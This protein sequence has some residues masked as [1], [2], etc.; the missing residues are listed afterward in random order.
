MSLLQTLIRGKTP[1]MPKGI[2][3]GPP[4]CGKTTFGA[5]APG[6]ILIDCENGANATAANRTPYLETWPQMQSWLRA[7]LDEKHE[8][9][10][11]VIDTIDWL[12]RRMEE[13]VSGAKADAKETLNRSHGGYGNGKQVLKNEIYLNLL[14][15]L[16]KLV[17]QGIGVILLAHASRQDVIDADGVAV[18]KTVPALPRDFLETFT[19]WSDF[20]C[21]VRRDRDGGRYLSTVEDDRVLA[22]NRYGLPAAIP[23]TWPDFS[24]EIKKF[25][26]VQSTEKTEK[27]EAAK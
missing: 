26:T 14:P 13:H 20:V 1:T 17:C 2:I 4:G 27:K 8:N 5:S 10:V 3:C 16:D 23:F 6:H 19:E 9:K 25:Y 15:M 21:T 24:G 22:K 18:E 12:V 7:L 11:V